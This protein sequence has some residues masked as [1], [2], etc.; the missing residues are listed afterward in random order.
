MKTIITKAAGFIGYHLAKYLA[1]QGRELIQEA[2]PEG[3]VNRR[4]PNITF[5]K[6]LGFIPEISFNEDL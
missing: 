5:L 2:S 1:Q 3:S 4:C 6:S